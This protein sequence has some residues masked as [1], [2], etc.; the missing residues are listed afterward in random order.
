VKR[1]VRQERKGKQ[2]GKGEEMAGEGMMRWKERRKES[3]TFSNMSFNCSLTHLSFPQYICLLVF[4][5][6]MIV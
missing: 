6:S 2:K 5:F 1:N 4:S 3:E